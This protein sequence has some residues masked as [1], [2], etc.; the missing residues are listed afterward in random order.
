MNRLLTTVTSQLV[1]PQTVA[2]VANI[3]CS[4]GTHV[5]AVAFKR[6]AAASVLS[7]HMGPVRYFATEGFLDKAQVTDRIMGVVKNF[8]KVDPT[9]VTPTAHF[10]EDLGLDS[11][12]AVEVVMAVE[13]EFAIEIPDAEADRILSVEDAIAYIAAHPMAK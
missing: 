6:P 4:R 13:D 3:V 5:A 9:K 2:R 7:A 1:R 8:E 10:K 11:L 12:D